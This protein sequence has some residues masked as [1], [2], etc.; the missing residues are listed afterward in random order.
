VL[1]ALEGQLRE[2]ARF[3]NAVS[4]K[5]ETYRYAPG[6]WTIRQVFGHLTDVERVFA[7]RAYCISRGETNTLP[8]FDENMYVERAPYEAIPLAELLAEFTAVRASNLYFLKR[9]DD[10]TWKRRGMAGTAPIT[11]RAL[12]Y[13]MAGHV[14]HHFN[15]LRSNYGILPG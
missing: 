12:A 2:S 11:V 4:P 13:L 3:A 6:K 1:A 7:Y 10:E 5:R 15:G 8:S 14:R 9:A